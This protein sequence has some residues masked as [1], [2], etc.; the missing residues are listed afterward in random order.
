MHTA[1][2]KSCQT[3]PAPVSPEMI[4]LGEERV[5]LQIEGY[6]EIEL[7]FFPK[8]A[9]V[10]VAHITK[11]FRMGCYDTNHVRISK[12]HKIMT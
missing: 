1:C 11:L 4:Q 6:G 7:G 3:C 2:G 9:P 10:T 8:A 12:R 5:T